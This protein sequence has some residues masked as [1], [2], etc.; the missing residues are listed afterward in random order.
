M[1]V[2]RY[3]SLSLQKA[4]DCLLFTTELCSILCDDFVLHEIIINDSVRIL[5]NATLLSQLEYFF[6]S[7]FLIIT[8]FN[9][10]LL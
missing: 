10:C 5:V 6:I 1:T 7:I 8:L 2:F 4:V 3:S 9:P